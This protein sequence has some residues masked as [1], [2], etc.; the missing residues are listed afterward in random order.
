MQLVFSDAVDS[1][2]SFEVESPQTD[3]ADSWLAVKF[4]LEGTVDSIVSFQVDSRLDDE[5]VGSCLVVYSA[6]GDVV[7]SIAGS[8][9]G[10][11]ETC[12][13]QRAVG[14]VGKSLIVRPIH[15]LESDSIGHQTEVVDSIA[16]GAG[17]RWERPLETERPAELLFELR[18]QL[19]RPYGE[20]Y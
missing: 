10:A 3:E 15:L 5:A 13:F 18:S 14:V 2:A 7:G 17:D 11:V 6:I 16:V 4:V 1:I 9:V 12:L 19:L 20:P 8:V